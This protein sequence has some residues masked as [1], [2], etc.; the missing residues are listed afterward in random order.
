MVLRDG[1]THTFDGHLGVLIEIRDRYGNVLSITRK[2][3]QCR[4]HDHPES[5]FTQWSIHHVQL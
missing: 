5:H 1:T 4:Q 3:A 2:S